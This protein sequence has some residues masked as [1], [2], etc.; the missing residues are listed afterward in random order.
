[1]A[2]FF[3]ASDVVVDWRDDRMG[4]LNNSGAE[5]DSREGGVWREMVGF[6]S[7]KHLDPVTLSLLTFIP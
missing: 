5:R 7:V 2:S 6:I 4:E 3:A 1:M